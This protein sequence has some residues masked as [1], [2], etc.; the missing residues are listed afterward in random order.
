[1][2]QG[3][4]LVEVSVP[5]EG[6]RATLSVL[7]LHHFQAKNNKLCCAPDCHCL[8]K[9]AAEELGLA[10]GLHTIPT[11]KAVA[12]PIGGWGATLRKMRSCEIP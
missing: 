12:V 7:S 5:S 2:S 9:Q 3:K 11:A 10:G 6:T 4:P 1:M 8:S